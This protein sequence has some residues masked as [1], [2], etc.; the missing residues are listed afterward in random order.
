MQ[1]PLNA[2]PLPAMYGGIGMPTLLT[3]QQQQQQPQPQQ[4]QQTLLQQAL[5]QQQRLI[6]QMAQI[7]QISQIP[8]SSHIP[9]TQMPSPLTST[10]IVLLLP[11]LF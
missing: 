10:F 4:T 8:L 9:Q 2:A 1:S 5:A 6:S 11:L 7:P 3:Q